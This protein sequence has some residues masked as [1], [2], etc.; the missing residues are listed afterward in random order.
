MLSDKS[1]QYLFSVIDSN[2]LMNK[3]LPRVQT[4]CIWWIWHSSLKLLGLISQNGEFYSKDASSP[5]KSW[6]QISI[7]QTV[8]AQEEITYIAIPY[9]TLLFKLNYGYHN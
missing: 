4:S 3:I 2:F 9:N 5:K 6:F 1:F 8:L 7:D